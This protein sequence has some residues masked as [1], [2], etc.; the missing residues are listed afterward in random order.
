MKR[1]ASLVHS[2]QSDV[3]MRMVCVV[4]N[5]CDPFQLG[6]KIALQSGHQLLR[7]GLQ[8]EPITKFRRDDDL[9]KTLVSGLLPCAQALRNIHRLLS[10]VE[11][12]SISF[13]FLG[14]TLT[15]QIVAVGFPLA[16]T[17]VR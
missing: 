13:C 1:L 11:A 15:C 10:A 6:P 9:E 4:V 17:L 5:D 14:C 12:S 3:N 8:V 2:P 16:S 7:V